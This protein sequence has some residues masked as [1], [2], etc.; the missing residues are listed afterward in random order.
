MSQELAP[1]SGEHQQA[2]PKVSL[3]VKLFVLFHILAITSWAIPN[4]PT[5]VDTGKVTPAGTQWIPYWNKLYLKNFTPFTDYLMISGFWQYWDMFAP[6][7]A[8][9]DTWGDAIV[10]FRDGSQKYYQ[11]PR[12]F[13]LSIPEKHV[14]ERYRKFFERAGDDKFKFLWPQFGFHIASMFDNPKNPPV[15]VKL[16]RHWRVVMGPGQPQNVDYKSFMF[17]E[18]FVDQA[19]LKQFRERYE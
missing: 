2:R 19:S 7:P 4:P 1:D 10:I 14:K 9:N 12:M 13:L 11:Y 16:Y 6:D 3:W 8:Q 18:Y 15:A 17:Y 5:A